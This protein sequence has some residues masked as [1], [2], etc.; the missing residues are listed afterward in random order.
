MREWIKRIGSAVDT[1]NN[2][3]EKGKASGWRVGTIQ[4][5]GADE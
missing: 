2:S 4:H 1:K 5:C 3:D